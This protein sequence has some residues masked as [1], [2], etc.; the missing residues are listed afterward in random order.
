MGGRSVPEPAHDEDED[1][2]DEDVDEEVAADSDDDAPLFGSEAEAAAEV[3]GIDDGGDF[4]EVLS[5]FGPETFASASACWAQAESQ[6]RFSLSSIRGQIGQE[7]WSDYHRIRLVNHLRT[8]GPE[9]ARQQAPLLTATSPIWSDDSLLQPVLEGD[10]LL[11]DASEMDEDED[12]AAASPPVKG[13]GGARGIEGGKGGGGKGALDV[14][15]AGDEEVNRLRAELATLRRLLAMPSQE[16]GAGDGGAAAEAEGSA[17]KAQEGLR[18]RQ[19]LASGGPAEALRALVARSG[20]GERPA[21]GR[22]VLNAG[23]SSG[24][25]NLV[26]AQLGAE[27]VSV[28]WSVAALGKASALAEANGLANQVKCF[29]GP[30]YDGDNSGEGGLGL[31]CDGLLCERLLSERRLSPALP[32]MLLAR[33]RHLRPSAESWVFP[34]RARLLLRAGDFSRELTEKEAL[35]QC[36]SLGGLDLSL[37]AAPVPEPLS[38]DAAVPWERLQAEGRVASEAFELLSLDL[39]TAEPEDALPSRVPFQL[40][41]RPDSCVT[42]LLLELEIPSYAQDGEVAAGAALHRVQTVLHLPSLGSRSGLLRLPGSE[43]SSLE[44]YL[45][46]GVLP[47]DEGGG[48]EV[49]VAVTA[50]R[51]GAG[52]RG[53]AGSS[54]SVSGTFRLPP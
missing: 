11:F 52:G 21:S 13:K 48:V 29:R 45:S 53:S 22:T 10:E 33:R 27:V 35:A 2:E 40:E 18:Q 26:C 36:Q 47:A 38:V 46:T 43:F 19:L 42:S 54:V 25:L 7:V 5:P 20:A 51:A 31:A 15:A 28:D 1:D 16:G 30:L 23:C 8:L 39:S 41:L 34:R 24:V 12:E 4:G 37:L 49:A 44:G 3:A 9:A 32:G 6:H 17:A 50:R 14:P